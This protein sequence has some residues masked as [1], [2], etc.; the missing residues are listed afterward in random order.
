MIAWNVSLKIPIALETIQTTWKNLMLLII[1]HWS[2]QL[3][4][5]MSRLANY[6]ALSSFFSRK[7]YWWRLVRPC[8]SY[9]ILS[10]SHI[11][12]RLLF[13]FGS[14][15]YSFSVSILRFF[16]YS[17]HL[18]ISF[19]ILF[20]ATTS[21]LIASF[22]ST[23]LASLFFSFQELVIIFWLFMALLLPTCI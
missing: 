11:L 21:S 18:F 3:S 4:Q 20:F 6:W 8:T 9:S 17:L 19:S 13:N 12:F 23:L 10:W 14:C 1:D 7:T 5:L 15:F 2:Y 16:C 22:W